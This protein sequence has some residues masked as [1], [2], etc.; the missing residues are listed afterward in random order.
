M[1]DC[2]AFN[3][4]TLKAAVRQYLWRENDATRNSLS[5]LAQANFPHSVLQG[6]KRSDLHE[7]LRS[8][9]INWNDL[10]SKYKR[11]TVVRRT[12]RRR[13]YSQEEIAALPPNHEARRNPDLIIERS[14]IEAVDLPPFSRIANK[15]GVL[16][17]GENVVFKNEM[18]GVAHD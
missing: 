13:S 14:V 7:L 8:K 2:R 17:K 4:A 16:F 15:V 11:G 18:E 9:G 10:P 6:K 12:K 5:M 1:F 3:V